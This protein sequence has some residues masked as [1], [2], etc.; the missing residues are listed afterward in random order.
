VLVPLSCRPTTAAPPPQ[1]QDQGSALKKAGERA[2]AAARGWTPVAL[3]R[4]VEASLMVGGCGKVVCLG[5]RPVAAEWRGMA[6]GCPVDATNCAVMEQG[7]A[8]IC[9]VQAWAGCRMLHNKG[10]TAIISWSF[11]AA[12]S[13]LC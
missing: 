2:C 5:G 7:P 10:G 8:A 1:V 11:S 4:Y 12:S 13:A 3:L 6:C 9:W